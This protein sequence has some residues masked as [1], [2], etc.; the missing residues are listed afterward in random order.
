MARRL[1]ATAA[2]AFA[3]A[4]CGGASSGSASPESGPNA[5]AGSVELV[6]IPPVTAPK[7]VTRLADRPCD[8]M[9]PEQEMAFELTDPM[10]DEGVTG[11]VKSCFWN[12]PG[13]I[14]V[15]VSAF[16]HNPTVETIYSN[17]DIYPIFELTRVSGYPA[18]LFSET[19][20]EVGSCAVAV[21]MAERQSVTVIYDASLAD[22]PPPD[23]CANAVRVAEVVLTNIPPA[24][25]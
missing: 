5:G 18:V 1:L 4:G 24:A 12:A 3:V 10:V 9:A 13:D 2:S 20:R 22:N 17:R 11:I 15:D 23:P 19:G 21:K 6:P 25:G 14:D 7:D 16:A 8:L